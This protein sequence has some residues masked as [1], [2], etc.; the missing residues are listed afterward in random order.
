MNAMP[1]QLLHDFANQILEIAN[2]YRDKS[3]NLN[4][5]TQR[6]RWLSGMWAVNMLLLAVSALLS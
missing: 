1:S 3:Q 6:F 2:I 4:Q 5:V